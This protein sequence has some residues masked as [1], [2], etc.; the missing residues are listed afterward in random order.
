MGRGGAEL[1]PTPNQDNERTK[2]GFVSHFRGGSP[3]LVKITF[4]V[5]YKYNDKKKARVGI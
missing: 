5:S 4:K 1:I 3:N 2:F